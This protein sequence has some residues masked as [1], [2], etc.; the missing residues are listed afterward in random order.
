MEGRFVEEGP[1]RQQENLL[2]ET[3]IQQ[4]NL[5]LKTEMCTRMDEGLKKEKNARPM[6]QNDLMTIKEKIQTD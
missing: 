2:L 5:L 4:E 3:E 6:V 1:K